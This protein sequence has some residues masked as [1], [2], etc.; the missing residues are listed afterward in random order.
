MTLFC[1]CGKLASSQIRNL[2]GV[3]TETFM[4]RRDKWPKTV[5]GWMNPRLK[6]VMCTVAEKNSITKEAAYY[7]YSCMQALFHS[8][9]SS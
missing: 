8:K 1:F 9:I 3:S 6:T 7:G 5:L 4:G 2:Q